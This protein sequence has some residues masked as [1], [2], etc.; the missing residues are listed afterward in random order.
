[1]GL[2]D[3]VPPGAF[4][5]HML[6]GDVVG[7]GPWSIS[8]TLDGV[9]VGADAPSRDPWLGLRVDGTTAPDGVAAA[10]RLGTSVSRRDGV[11]VGSSDG[12]TPGILPI[13]ILVC[14]AV[15]LRPGVAVGV[16]VSLS[17][18]SSL[19]GGAHTGAGEAV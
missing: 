10:V 13:G 5:A 2:N 3:G 1:M 19:A 14:D 12:A 11:S 16:G 18:D 6:V 15:G 7:Y 9:I 17:P 4:S 8:S